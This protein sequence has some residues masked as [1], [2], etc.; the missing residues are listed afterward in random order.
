MTGMIEIQPGALSGIGD[1]LDTA[2]RTLHRHIDIAVPQDMPGAR[3]LE[4]GR[5]AFRER[6]QDHFNWA[7][8][9]A[10]EC[11]STANDFTNTDYAVSEAVRLKFMPT[12]QEQLTVPKTPQP[13]YQLPQPTP[14]PSPTPGD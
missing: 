13:S 3:A 9:L 11:D 10:E 8:W 6:L 1:S 14:Q 5:E 12:I 7:K 4:R 2:S